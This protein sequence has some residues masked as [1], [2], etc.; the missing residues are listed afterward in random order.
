MPPRLF[1]KHFQICYVVRD[2]ERAFADFKDRFGITK[3]HQLDVASDPASPASTIALAY[4]DDLMIEL[5]EPFPNRPSFY[6]GW[7]TG[8]SRVRLHHL[9]FLLH[10]DA[11][12][13]AAIDQFTANGYPVAYA[14]SAGN[15][16]DF[17]YADSTAELGH[18]LELIHL[19]PAGEAFFASVPHN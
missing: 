14:G 17:H 7:L 4:V 3:W 18:F 13:R 2:A 9:G 16:L 6:Q 15:M 12:W 10:D 1:A 5:V 8:T 19:K 11:E